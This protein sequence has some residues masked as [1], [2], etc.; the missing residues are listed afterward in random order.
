MES[1]NPFKIGSTQFED[2]KTMSDLKWHCSKC[3][4]QSAQA[5]TWQVWRQE[6][7]IQLDTDNKGNHFLRKLC[8]ICNNKTVHRKLQTTQIFAETK[9]RSGISSMLRKKVIRVL[10]NEEA[11]LKRKLSNNELEVDH[12]FPQ[13]RWKG[14]EEKNEETMTEKEIKSKFILLNRSNNLTKSRQ[15]EKCKKTGL[16]GTFSGINFWYEGSINW[17]GKNESDAKGCIGCFGMILTNGE[18]S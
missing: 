2:F 17:E 16:R 6:K 18:I 3:E 5:K 12:K 10:N 11:I 1:I 8:N 13:V 15:C 9:S 4:L 7:G 14:D